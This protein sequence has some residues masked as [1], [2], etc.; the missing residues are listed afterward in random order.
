MMDHRRATLSA[1]VQPL[2][3][4]DR[5]FGLGPITA[6]WRPTLTGT[7]PNKPRRDLMSQH[8][9]PG[10]RAN[11]IETGT[12]RRRSLRKT[13][14]R[15]VVSVGVLDLSLGCFPVCWIGLDPLPSRSHAAAAGLAGPLGSTS[16]AGLGVRDRREPRRQPLPTVLRGRCIL[17]DGESDFMCDDSS[18]RCPE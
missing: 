7:K 3:V 13:R 1:G 4:L 15:M 17:G 2:W 6:H 16:G 14:R 10:R 5:P 9:G 12:V 8:V 11:G 18:H